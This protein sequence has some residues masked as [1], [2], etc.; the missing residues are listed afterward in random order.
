MSKKENRYVVQMEMYVYADNDYMAKKRA[1]DLRLSIDN[2]RHSQDVTVKE[3]G[4]QPFGSFDYRKLDDP[5][6]IPKDESD[7][8][9]PF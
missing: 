4:E 5:T 8:P 1:N 3:I 7:K 2:R 6:F 9:L